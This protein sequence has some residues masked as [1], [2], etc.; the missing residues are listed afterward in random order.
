MLA[1][2]APNSMNETFVRRLLLKYSG[3]SLPNIEHKIQALTT[4][5][6]LE[7]D[8]TV[9]IITTYLLKILFNVF[10]PFIFWTQFSH[11]YSVRFEVVIV[12]TEKYCLL[13]YF[14]LI[15]LFFTWPYQDIWWRVQ[16]MMLLVM[17]CCLVSVA[18]FLV[19]NILLR[20]LFANAQANVPGLLFIDLKVDLYWLFN[21]TF[22][23]KCRHLVVWTLIICENSLNTFMKI[24]LL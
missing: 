16:L 13:C 12:V 15:S 8:E 6:Y 9:I 17:Q 1:L 4:I 11:L 20:L 14:M 23:Y 10:S 3:T 7:P 18:S 21:E 19:P 2:G 5:L 22:D 24:F